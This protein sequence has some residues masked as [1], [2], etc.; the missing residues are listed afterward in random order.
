MKC[1]AIAALVA[2]MKHIPVKALMRVLSVVVGMAVTGASAQASTL[3]DFGDHTF[4]SA[5]DLFWLDLTF[6]T[7]LSYI[8]VSSQLGDGGQFDGYRYATFAEVSQ[9]WDNAD[10]LETGGESLPGPT[11]QSYVDYVNWFGITKASFQVGAPGLSA[12]IVLSPTETYG[13]TYFGVNIN[14][15]DSA[16]DWQTYWAAIIPGWTG[17]N[18]AFDYVGSYLVTNE[19]PPVPLPAALP[20]LMSALGFFGFLGWRRKKADAKYAI[21]GRPE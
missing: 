20:L 16:L 5:T 19:I 12:G 11:P 21:S 2:G 3:Q 18:N 14:Q 9:M 4:D 17:T 13:V 7:D 10:V 6:S 15:P 1:R 8:Y